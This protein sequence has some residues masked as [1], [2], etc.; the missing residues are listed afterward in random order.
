MNNLISIGEASELLD[1]HRDTLRRWEK[2]GWIKSYRTEGN[3][4]RYN[5]DELT[6]AFY[7]IY[8]YLA[9][10]KN[11]YVALNAL[12][13]EQLRLLDDESTTDES[14]ISQLKEISRSKTEILKNLKNGLCL[15]W[16]NEE[17]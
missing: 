5:R 13:N 4:R 17:K 15:L 10:V 2:R 14:K 3:H 8:P 7:K 16:N 1:L 9:P 11:N 12:H 6:K